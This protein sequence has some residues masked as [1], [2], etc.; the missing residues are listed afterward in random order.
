MPAIGPYASS[1]DSHRLYDFPMKVPFSKRKWSKALK[2]KLCIALLAKKS[3]GSVGRGFC[4][5]VVFFPIGPT[6]EEEPFG[7]KKRRNKRDR[8]FL[9]FSVSRKRAIKTVFFNA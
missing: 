8:G 7:R 3:G 4:F 5:V 2:I 1:K 6:P 9:T